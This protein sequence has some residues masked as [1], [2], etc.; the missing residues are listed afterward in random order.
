M[1]VD[2]RQMMNTLDLIL[3]RFDTGYVKSPI[4]IHNV[5]RTIMAKVI[6]ELGFRRGVEVGIAEGLHASVL[7]KNNPNLVLD[8]VD[9]Y[10]KYPGYE[11]YDDP[12]KY[13]L[14]AKERLKDYKF[15][16]VKKYSMDAVKDYADNSLDF[17][18]IDGAHDFK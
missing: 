18:Y 10:E 17:V 7:C 5:N 13:Y 9:C 11:E 14:E 4:E 16:F 8:G 2:K 15:T 3:L 1:D 6:Q 12:N